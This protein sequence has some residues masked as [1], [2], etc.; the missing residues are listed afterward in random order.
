MTQIIV[1][2]T[3]RPAG[4]RYGF[5][6][7]KR[8][9]PMAGPAKALHEGAKAT[10]Y[11]CLS[12]LSASIEDQANAG[13]CVGWGTQQARRDRMIVQGTQDAKLGA[14]L[15]AY[16]FGRLWGLALE[17]GCTVA[18]VEEK[19]A[20]GEIVLADD[21]CMIPD[22]IDG[23][24]ALGI[25]AEEWAPYSDALVLEATLPLSAYQHAYDQRG[26]T[27]VHRCADTREQREADIRGCI[28]ADFPLLDGVQVDD[29]FEQ[30]PSGLW[31]FKGRSLG[32]HCMEIVAYDDLGV[33]KRNQW[34]IW[35]RSPPALAWKWIDSSGHET[36]PPACGFIHESWETALDPNVT[37]DL[38][39]VQWAP[40]YSEDIPTT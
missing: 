5:K 20:T 11:G 25:C 1:H 12:K 32:G 8:K 7:D 40:N 31:T 13:S 26:T 33:W 15:V 10:T 14:P 30:G 6:A 28:D 16:L 3:E 29:G 34:G 22:A 24:N 37:A 19:I 4:R 21:G 38:Y 35:G 36:A 2:D 18:Q 27:K 23:I 17:H 9:R 39:A